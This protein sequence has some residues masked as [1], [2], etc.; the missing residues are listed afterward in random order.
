MKMENLKIQK[1]SSSPERNKNFK[2][3]YKKFNEAKKNINV[4]VPKDFVVPRKTVLENL[5][6]Y[7]NED[8]ILW[9]NHASFFIK[10]GSTT[11]VTDLITAKNTGPLNF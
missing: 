11:I 8:F 7:K 9:I 6:K 3:S 10:L 1:L 5:E 2:W 4:I